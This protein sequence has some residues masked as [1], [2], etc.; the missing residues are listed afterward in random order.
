[1]NEYLAPTSFLDFDEPTVAQFARDTVG[2][3]GDAVQ[4]AVRL[5]YAVRDSIPYN[6]YRLILTP[7]GMRA[8]AVLK[9]RSGYCVAKAVLL[10]AAGRAVGIPTR[11]GFADVRNHMTSARLQALMKTDVFV[12]HGY[13][14]FHLDG[15]WLKL[16]P[17]FDAALCERL[18]LAPLE[19][20]G[21]ADAVSQAFSTRGERYLE[22]LRTH[23]S[24]A[25]LPL[26][27]II[28][29]FRAA[30]PDMARLLGGKTEVTLD[31]SFLAEA[32]RGL[33]R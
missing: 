27:Q 9:T 32:R 18:H 14:E 5:F 15:R 31:G 8:S 10:A 11:L 17:A 26:E 33:R 24:F 25:D 28:E 6:P 21:T 4:H 22:S 1:V 13:A 19:F 3:G 30:Y 23:G 7:E 12:W 29:G 2:E 20:D 16:T